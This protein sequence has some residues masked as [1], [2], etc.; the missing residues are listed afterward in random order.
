[1]A[2]VRVPELPS[3]PMACLDGPRVT[4]EECPQLGPPCEA[5]FPARRA[6]GRMA[7]QPRTARQL[8]VSPPVPCRRRQSGSATCSPT[9]KP[10]PAT[11]SRGACVVGCRATPSR[12]APSS[13]PCG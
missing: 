9:C 1:M 7:G 6:A 8:R 10:P 3:R 5:A 12:G 4:L 2:G 13:G 11:W